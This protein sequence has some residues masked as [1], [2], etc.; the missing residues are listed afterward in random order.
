VRF[1][2]GWPGALAGALLGRVLSCAPPPELMAL[3][4]AA[5]ASQ[6]INLYLRI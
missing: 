6:G 5:V 2:P 1:G 3:I 4:E